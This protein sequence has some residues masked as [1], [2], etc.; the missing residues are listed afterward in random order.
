MACAWACIDAFDSCREEAFV[1][2]AQHALQQVYVCSTSEQACSVN[3]QRPLQH[4]NAALAAD[5]ALTAL[6]CHQSQSVSQRAR[7][8]HDLAYECLRQRGQ[9][10]KTEADFFEKILID[11]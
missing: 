10:C 1:G 3:W 6:R 11:V 8:K 9:G 5:I 7:I 4:F 2:L